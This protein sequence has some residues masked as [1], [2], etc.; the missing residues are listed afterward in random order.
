MANVPLDT[1][2]VGISPNVNLEE[3]KSSVLNSETQPYTMQDIVDTANSGNTSMSFVAKLTQTG[4]AN[5]VATVYENTAEFASPYFVRQEAGVYTMA[6]PVGYTANKVSV[7][8]NNGMFTPNT[9]I[10]FDDTVETV[11]I[12]TTDSGLP[13]DDILAYCTVEVKLFE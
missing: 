4:T 6:L 13:A 1:R 5:P 11:N 8:I 12:L 9:F 10:S 7:S 3:K 2:F